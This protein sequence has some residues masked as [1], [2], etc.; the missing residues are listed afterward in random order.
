MPYRVEHTTDPAAFLALA[1][2]HLAA[3][4]VLSTVV[5]TTLARAVSDPVSNGVYERIGYRPVAEMVR[6]EVVAEPV[7]VTTPGPA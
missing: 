7:G 6:M 2:A 5:S 3:E 4:P 1:E